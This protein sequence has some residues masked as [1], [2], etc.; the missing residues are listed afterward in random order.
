M[1]LNEDDR[2]KVF[3]IIKKNA[4]VIG[5]IKWCINELEKENQDLLQAWRD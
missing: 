4:E 2:A 3:A 1:P 5:W